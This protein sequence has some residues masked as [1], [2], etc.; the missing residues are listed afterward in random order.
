MSFDA[1]ACLGMLLGALLMA[2]LYCLG[3]FDP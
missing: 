3:W 1:L 2:A